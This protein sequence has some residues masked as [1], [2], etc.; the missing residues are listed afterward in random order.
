MQNDKFAPPPLDRQ[1]DKFPQPI[2]FIPGQPQPGYPQPGYPQPGHPP[3]GYPAYTTPADTYGHPPPPPP[4]QPPRDPPTRVDPPREGCFKRNRK[5]KPQSNAVSPAGL[6]FLSGGMNIAWAIG[7]R[8]PIYYSSTTH[9]YVAWFI[10]AFIGA[11]L[12]I[13]L[14]N[15]LAKKYSLLIASLLVTIGGFVIACTHNNGPATVAACYLDGIANGLVFAPFVALAGEVTVPYMRGGVTASL[16]QLCFGVGIL[17]QIVY[18]VSW[19]YPYYQSYNDYT[20]ENMKG[21]LSALFGILATIYGFLCIIESPV[22]MLVN[23]DEQG[24]LDALRRLQKPSV[25]TE[26][27]YDLLAQHKRYVAHNKDLSSGEKL[28][29]TSL[30]FIRLAYLRVLNA[31]SLSSFV[32][33]T[34]SLSIYLSYGLSAEQLWF[35]LFA[36]CRWAG[37]I[38]P[39]F[40]MDSLG[41]KLPTVFGLLLSSA[42]AFAVGAKFSYYN[43]MSGV[44][45]LLS[46]FEFF[47]G[48]ASS[49]TSSYLSEAYPLEFKQPAIALTFIIEMFVFFIIRFCNY[50][51][52]QGDNYFYVMGAMYLVG[53]IL[54]VISL[55]ET[56]RMTLRGAQV[57]FSSFINKKFN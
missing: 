54:G 3:Q 25:L 6:I 48:M 17:L 4:P 51:F 37:T 1:N 20:P 18:S 34:L 16:E 31:M 14:A 24:A 27:T 38:I 55:P 44:T 15:R 7:F 8:G 56:K 42:F 13:L 40:F 33:T 28:S 53:F 21:V 30:T 46:V 35:I 9:N 39:T 10:G 43:Y 52:M 29:Q 12:S 22:Q 23:D 11:L 36:L 19:T 57:Q 5:N 32:T 41:R 2:G 49:A 26:E 45:I 50:N 47:A